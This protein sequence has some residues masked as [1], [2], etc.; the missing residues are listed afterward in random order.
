MS[1]AASAISRIVLLEDPQRVGIG[2][3]DGRHGGVQ[4]TAQIVHIHGA[5]GVAAHRD[6]LQAGQRGR[7][8]VGA[9]GG[10][11]MRTRSGRCPPGGVIRLDHAQPGPLAVGTRRRLERDP[12]HAGD[13]PE[14]L[15]Q[16]PHQLERPLDVVGVLVGVDVGEARQP[17]ELLVDHGV[18]LHG[19][20]AQRVDAVV[21]V[22]VASRQPAEVAGQHRLGHRGDRRRRR[23]QPHS[24]Q[25][26]GERALGDP[27]RH[28]PRPSLVVGAQLEDEGLLAGPLRRRRCESHAAAPAAVKRAAAAT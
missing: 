19:A 2:H 28:L 22:V 8:R 14:Q 17:G 15:F 24:R 3:H 12:C 25:Q 27:A 4:V 10:V 16:I 26:F 6:H 20:A 7:G 18:V 13:L 5:G 9:V 11:G 23:A 21:Q 1:W